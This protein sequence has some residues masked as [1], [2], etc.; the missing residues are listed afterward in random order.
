MRIR[1]R[2]ILLGLVVGICISNSMVSLNNK[3]IANQI[4]N[5]HVANYPVVQIDESGNYIQNYGQPMPI[6]NNYQP[7]HVQ[8]SQHPQQYQRIIYGQVN[9]STTQPINVMVNTG[10]LPQQTNDT[11]A[12]RKLNAKIASKQ[13]IPIEFT[14]NTNSN[15]LNVGDRV[16]IKVTS[17]IYLANQLVFNKNATGF[18]IVKSVKPSRNL[19]KG[20]YIIFKEGYIKDVRGMNRQVSFRKKIQ[21]KNCKWAKVISHAMI[22]NP[23]GWIIA[24]K[25]GDPAYINI[26]DI[27]TCKTTKNFSL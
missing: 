15:E 9:N 24:P 22:W 3:A 13:P 10:Y 18:L 26:G 1:K 17:D 25:E 21:G 20:G 8:Y 11:Y 27:A 2:I 12:Q 16:S 14:E 4:N 5:A 23:I 7:Q 6:G 19:G